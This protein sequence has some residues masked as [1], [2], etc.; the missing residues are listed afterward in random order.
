MKI[1]LDF[2]VES[3]DGV[4]L[5]TFTD[6]AEATRW[7]SKLSAVVAREERDEYGNRVERRSSASRARQGAPSAGKQ[8]GMERVE[9]KKNELP[10]RAGQI[11]AA[12]C[13]GTGGSKFRHPG[14][15]KI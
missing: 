7:L 8:L 9:R 1:V 14:L 4:P 3:D 2:L 10:P 15:R 12:F 5:R 11:S 13:F 6:E